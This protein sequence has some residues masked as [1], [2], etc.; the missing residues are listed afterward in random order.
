MKPWLRQELFTKKLKGEIIDEYKENSQQCSS[1]EEN[2]FPRS[3]G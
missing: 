2:N 3:R 1:E